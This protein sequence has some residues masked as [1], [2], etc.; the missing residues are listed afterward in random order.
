MLLLADKLADHDAAADAAERAQR[1]P[2]HHRVERDNPRR[3]FKGER[4]EP[5]D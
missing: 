1:R 4:F 2:H 5:A 3:V